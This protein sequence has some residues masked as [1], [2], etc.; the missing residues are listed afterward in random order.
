[1][2]DKYY[3]PD[4]EYYLQLTNEMDKLDYIKKFL[5]ELEKERPNHQ[6]YY[7]II[8]SLCNKELNKLQ[9]AIDSLCSDE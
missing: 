3:N 9:E 8:K 4:Y 7:K 5:I 2:H 1:M 6:E